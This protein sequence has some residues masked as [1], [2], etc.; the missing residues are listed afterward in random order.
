MVAAGLRTPNCSVGFAHTALV[1][2]Q[3]RAVQLHSDKREATVSEATSAVST[4]CTE[5]TA[6]PSL[7]SSPGIHVESEQNDADI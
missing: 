4:V 6:F 3:A 7:S 1:P 5:R 2:V